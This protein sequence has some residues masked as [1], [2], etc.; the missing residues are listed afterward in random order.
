MRQR[1]LTAIVG[2]LGLATVAACGSTAA[3]TGLN[4]AKGATTTAAAP[5]RRPA[6]PSHSSP[7]GT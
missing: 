7:R 3:P 2:V 4:T 6:I 5:S 1:R